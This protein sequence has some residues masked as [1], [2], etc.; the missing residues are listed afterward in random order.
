MKLLRVICRLAFGLLFVLAGFLKAIDPIGTALKIKEYIG[1]FHLSIIDFISIPFALLLTCAEFLVGVAILKGLRMQLFSKI[2]LAFISFF[3]LLTLWIA[4]ANPVSDC[5]CFGEVIHLSNKETFIKNLLLLFAA[6]IIYFQRDKYHKIARPKVEWGYLAIYAILI[7]G[8]QGYSL[9]NIPQIDFGIYKPGTD[10][11]TRQQQFQEREY[12]TTFIYSKDG[13]EKTFTLN[14]IPDSTWTF[15]DAKSVLV[16]GAAE[17]ASID[18]SFMDAQ[19]NPIGNEIVQSNGPVFFISIYNARAL[20][21]AAVEKI[22]ALADTLHKHNLK[23]YIISANTVE[24]TQALFEPYEAE[25]GRT[26]SILYS[27]Y[28][29]VISFNRSSGGL[30]YVNSGIIIKKW[31]RGN[32]P[33]DN[34]TQILEE[35]PE[36]I[37]AQT[38]ISEQLFAEIS[39]FVILCLIMFI[40]VVSRFVY[41]HMHENKQENQEEEQQDVPDVQGEQDKP[42][43]QDEEP[44]ENEEHS[45]SQQPENK[46]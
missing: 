44:Q 31:A 9:R 27:D 30:T 41:K 25:D 26:Y 13:E 37:T 5:G 1:V 6:L 39:L 24:T 3:T 22:M 8:L 11:I 23:L 36:I 33:L 32:Y 34:I 17:D 43:E 4:I 35:D 46:E 42:G 14:D 10:L 16:R 21:L 45:I 20:Q 12:E 2:A 7:I 40:R 38:R 19:G 28:K 18:F 15:V 29:A